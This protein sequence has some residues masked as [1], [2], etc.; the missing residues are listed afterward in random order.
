M[1]GLDRRSERF[2]GE[3][4]GL[5]H[6]PHG[7]TARCG[8]PATTITYAEYLFAP[9]PTPTTLES[10][11]RHARERDATKPSLQHDEHARFDRGELY[12]HTE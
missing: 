11:S 4:I 1:D 9:L 8:S 6:E 2:E 3:L 12:I 10:N 7:E 5:P